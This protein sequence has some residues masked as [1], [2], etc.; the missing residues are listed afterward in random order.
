MNGDT[1]GNFNADGSDRNFFLDFPLFHGYK[2]KGLNVTLTHYFKLPKELSKWAMELLRDNMMDLY[3]ECRYD[4][5]DLEKRD[6]FIDKAA[7]F[8]VATVRRLQYPCLPAGLQT[9]RGGVMIANAAAPAWA[10]A[11]APQLSTHSSRP[12]AACVFLA[13]PPPL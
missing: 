11:C 13:R 7:R 10:V 2:K 4:W 9:V 8:I 1:N 12:L 5:D 6:D 3:N